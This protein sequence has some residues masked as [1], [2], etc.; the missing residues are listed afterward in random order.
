[1]ELVFSLERET[2]NMKNILG[3][4]KVERDMRHPMDMGIST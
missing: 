1:M 2:V 3:D 4:D